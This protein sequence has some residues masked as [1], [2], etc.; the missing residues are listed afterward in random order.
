[1][2]KPH[3]GFKWRRTG[4]VDAG[5]YIP[6]KDLPKKFSSFREGQVLNQNFTS[7]KFCFSVEGGFFHLG[8]YN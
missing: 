5:F 2:T 1:M 6:P 8:L 7:A 4:R 3:K